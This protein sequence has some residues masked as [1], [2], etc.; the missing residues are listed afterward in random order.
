[1]PQVVHCKSCH[2]HVIVDGFRRDSGNEDGGQRKNDRSIFRI[3]PTVSDSHT[4]HPFPVTSSCP[5]QDTERVLG[6][7][8][9]PS[10]VQ[11]FLQLAG[12]LSGEVKVHSECAD[13][14]ETLMEKQYLE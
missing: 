10:A 8:H 3:I 12:H 6:C 4:L 5:N 11:L 2:R 13:G 14:I 1:M 7:P 9:L